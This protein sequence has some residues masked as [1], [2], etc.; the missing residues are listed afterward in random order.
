MSSLTDSVITEMKFEEP[1]GNVYNHMLSIEIMSN[2]A[3]QGNA[4]APWYQSTVYKEAMQLYYN[5]Q[6]VPGV[7]CFRLSGQED[8][9][10]GSHYWQITFMTGIVIVLYLLLMLYKDKKNKYSFGLNVIYILQKYR[11]LIKQLVSRDFKT[12][13]KR[14]ALGM[15]WSFL[16]PLLTMLVQYFVFSTI[17]KAEIEHYPVYL[18]AGIVLF[19]F[20]S[21]VTGA[22][23]Y[24]ILANASLIKKVYV[25]KYIY[26]VSKVLSS[27]LNLVISLLPLFLVAVVTKVRLSQV[28]LITPFVLLCLMVFS[29]GIGFILSAGMV[30]FRDVQ[31]IWSVISM[32]WMYGT[33]IFYP[34]SILPE[35]FAGWL[36]FNPLYCYIQFFRI[37][38]IEGISPEPMMYVKCLLFAL[39]SLIIG[40]LIF[41]KGQDKFVL[42]L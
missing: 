42:Y 4:V 40:A 24:A 16:N 20:F 33:P 32:V 14:S 41:K 28:L 9:W 25:P 11:F 1:I 6:P 5:D 18:L 26:P 21:E 36:E 23:I 30:F 12:K 3:W 35:Q 19:G 29:L 38:L 39:S 37:L 31:F 13:Y 22:C 15:L 17:F 8:V 34:E 10:T 27:A 7:L 2:A